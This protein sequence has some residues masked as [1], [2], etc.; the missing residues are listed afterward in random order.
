MKIG[1]SSALVAKPLQNQEQRGAKVLVKVAYALIYA[2]GVGFY[3]FAINTMTAMP[4]LQEYTARELAL[5]VNDRIR[6][7]SF[8][9]MADVLASAKPVRDE[10]LPDHYEEFSYTDF[11]WSIAS[12][13]EAKRDEISV[14]IYNQVVAERA[15]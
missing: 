3:I 9:E 10:D 5:I 12:E 7:N 13:N 2:G 8:S 15:I 14:Q 11:K 6:M 4:P 1:A